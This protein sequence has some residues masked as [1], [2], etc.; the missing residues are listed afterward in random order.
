[1]QSACLHRPTLLSS[2]ELEHHTE[3]LWK[4]LVLRAAVG[5]LTLAIWDLLG[6]GLVFM[7]CKSGSQ[8][9]SSQ[10]TF[11]CSP[12]NPTQRAFLCQ[13]YICGWE[14]LSECTNRLISSRGFL[15]PASGRSMPRRLER[16][17]EEGRGLPLG[18]AGAFEAW[19]PAERGA[20]AAGATLQG[21]GEEAG[22]GC[23]PRGSRA[24]SR[25]P[26]RPL[27]GT[28]LRGLTARLTGGGWRASKAARGRQQ[29]KYLARNQETGILFCH[30]QLFQE[31]LWAPWFPCC[32]KV[33]L[34]NVPWYPWNWDIRKE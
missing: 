24:R 18:G 8:D 32:R 21:C 22:A 26:T 2:D 9:P 30:L 10:K 20:G 34:A 12:E 14:W 31:R 33:L 29:L 16:G 28:W 11:K 7:F 1:M 6:L 13:T 3:K 5:F 23:G 19:P 15:I 27:G 17:Q 25:A 4:C